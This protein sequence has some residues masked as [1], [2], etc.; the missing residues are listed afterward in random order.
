MNRYIIIAL[1]ALSF[2]LLFQYFFGNQ[3]TKLE[4]MD[5]VILSIIDDS[6]VIPNAPKI[7]IVNETKTGVTFETCKDISLSADSRPLTNLQE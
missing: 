4:A 7:E 2:T 3:E 1:Y 6:V 5:D